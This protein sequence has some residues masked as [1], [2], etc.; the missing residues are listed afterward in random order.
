MILNHRIGQIIYFFQIAVY[1]MFYARS[2]KLGYI[3][4]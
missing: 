2:F 3:T 1:A 4:C